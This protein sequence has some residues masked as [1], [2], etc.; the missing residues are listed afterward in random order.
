LTTFRFKRPSK[1]VVGRDEG[2]ETVGPGRPLETR[3]ASA[4]SRGGSREVAERPPQRSDEGSAWMMDKGEA[5]SLIRFSCEPGSNLLEDVHQFVDAYAKLRFRPSV[6]QRVSLAAYELFS[7]AL[8]YGSVSSEV[9]FEVLEKGGLVLIRVQNDAI[10]ARLE[11]LG[12]RVKRL[13]R[14]PEATFVEEMRRYVGGGVSRAMLG[15]ARVRHEAQMDL[16]VVV[17]DSRV[18]VTASC[19]R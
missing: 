12:D 3:V 7:N 5:E 9:V 6:A 14:D 19:A 10:R 1:P 15:L 18:V 8:S 2:T 4:A 16:D 11:M 13:E 17:A